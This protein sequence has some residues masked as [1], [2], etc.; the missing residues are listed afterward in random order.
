MSQSIVCTDT[1]YYIIIIIIIIIIFIIIIIIIIIVITIVIILPLSSLLL[2]LLWLF[3]SLLLLF[4]TIVI[5]IITLSLSLLRLWLLY[6]YHHHYDLYLAW[7]HAHL[8]PRICTYSVL[9]SLL[10]WSGNGRFHLIPLNLLHWHWDSNTV[11]SVSTQQMNP[12]EYRLIIH[13]NPLFYGIYCVIYILCVVLS[14]DRLCNVFVIII[15]QP[16]GTLPLT[17]IN[18]LTLGGFDYSLKLGNFKLIST[19]NILRI[20]CEILIRWMPQHLTDH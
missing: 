6:N 18:S 10:L 1:N 14:N 3:L 11:A 19:I 4:I 15:F 13:V 17:W 9:S 8:A 5:I 16:I 7:E 20:S 2:L 12:E